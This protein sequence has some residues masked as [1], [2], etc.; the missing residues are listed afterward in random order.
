MIMPAPDADPGLAPLQDSY[1][2]L[3]GKLLAGP[4][5]GGASGPETER[6]ASLL[7]ATGIRC[8][9][10]LTEHHEEKS[11]QRYEEAF[12]RLARERELEVHCIRYSLWD[13][14]CPSE[15]AVA[16]L[17][18]VIDVCIERDLP[19]YVHC[20][21][22]LGR[23]GVM[24]GCYLVRHGFVRGRAAVRRLTRLRRQTSIARIPSPSTKEQVARVRGWRKGR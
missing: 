3:P 24:A 11:E 10:N 16:E 17:L 8:V 4:H 18:D 13:G 14:T 23:T 9:V 22:G 20:M 12:S 6:R 19:V 5:P 15:A 2:V 1:W 7:L 21:A